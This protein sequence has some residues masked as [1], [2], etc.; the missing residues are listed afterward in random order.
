MTASMY[1]TRL[2][3]KISTAIPNAI[4]AVPIIEPRVSIVWSV[5]RR[6]SEMNSDKESD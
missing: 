6:E 2:V 5:A 4:K 1:Q 3:K